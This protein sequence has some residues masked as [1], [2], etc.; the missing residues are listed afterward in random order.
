MKVASRL[1][2]FVK[3]LS[4]GFLEVLDLA[5]ASRIPL[6][7][8]VA[9]VLKRVLAE[10]LVRK[11]LFIKGWITVSWVIIERRWTFHRTA[12]SCWCFMR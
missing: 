6:E 12:E 11:A 2:G 10:D 9:G 5:T 1:I 8:L 3:G 4:A 7:H